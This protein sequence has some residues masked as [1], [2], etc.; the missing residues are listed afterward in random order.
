MRKLAAMALL[1]CAVPV[2]A[3]EAPVA[4]VTGGP[5]SS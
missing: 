1:C 4:K 5:L 2:A 3:Q